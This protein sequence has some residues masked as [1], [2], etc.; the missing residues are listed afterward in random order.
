M[1]QSNVAQPYGQ[2]GVT[3]GPMTQRSPIQ[4]LILG[5]VTIGIYSWVWAIKTKTE[6]NQH[7]AQIPTAWIW[8]IPGFG[9]LYWWWKYSEGVEMVT[10]GQMT[11]ATAFVLFLLT[12]AIGQ[13][14]V[15]SAYNKAA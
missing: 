1:V 6:L 10:K 11:K 8:L 12:G 3:A 9:A 15:Q 5:I 14:V 2:V 4:V 7:G 13:A